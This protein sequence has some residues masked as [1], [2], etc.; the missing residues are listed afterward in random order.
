ML[1]QARREYRR[2]QKIQM[3]M[4]SAL[5]EIPRSDLD[6]HR[7]GLIEDRASGNFFHALRGE[8]DEPKHSSA[9]AHFLTESGDPIYLE[10]PSS[11]PQDRAELEARQAALEQR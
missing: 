7:F 3:A 10:R 11:P 9:V 2:H 8:L 6:F 5:P 1:K 4:R